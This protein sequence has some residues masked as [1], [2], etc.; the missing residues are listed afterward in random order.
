MIKSHLLYQLSYR[1][2]VLV[3]VFFYRVANIQLY[4]SKQIAICQYAARKL[5]ACGDGFIRHGF[6]TTHR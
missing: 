6:A 4:V 5:I 3:P 2:V 1:V